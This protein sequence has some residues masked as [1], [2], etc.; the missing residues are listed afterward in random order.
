MNGTAN[1]YMAGALGI[2]STSLT[3]FTLRLDKNITGSANP[4][5]FSAGG[6]IQTDATGVVVLIGT[7]LQTVA[8]ANSANV[9]HYNTGTG[10]IGAG[11]V[12]GNLYGYVASG[13]TQGTNNFGFYGNIAAAANRYNLY[14][15]GTANNYMAGSLGIGTTSF[16]FGGGTYNLNLTKNITGTVV[17]GGMNIGSIVNS[18]VTSAA[19][20]LNVQVTTAA[21]AF[22]LNQLRHISVNQTTL[23]AGS[24]VSNQYG[25]Y[26]DQI[27]NGS[28]NFGFFGNVPAG[29][30]RWNIY[31]AGTAN[32]FLAGSLGI[33]STALTQYNVRMQK[34][35]TGAATSFGMWI[36]SPI[37]SDVTT[38]A[39]IFG[40]SPST[41]AA[42]FTLG[43]LY[44]FY[45]NQST[46]GAGSSITNQ[47]GFFADSGL[48]GATND[49]GFFGNLA[50]GT[51]I[52][53]LYMA[54]TAANYMAGNLSIGTTSTTYQLNV[55]GGG[56]AGVLDSAIFAATG[57]GG[58]GRGVGIVL[59]ASGSSSS[60]QVARLVGYQ[61][62]ASATANNAS[63]AIQV[64]NSSG[65]LTERVRVKTG[66]QMRFVPLAADPSGA[67]AGDVYYNSTTNKLKVYNGTAWETITSL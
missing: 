23:G 21:A 38:G 52:W 55:Q 5:A 65:T 45:A 32:N 12:I 31:M 51:N 41:Q 36:D 34:N 61:E 35:I 53:N 58:A 14:M 6:T 16:V 59:G 19:I 47:Y 26:V 15:N 9:Y 62:T 3:G 43:N 22:T 60:V 63:F 24:S 54:G 40:T 18:D 66:G 7:S 17:A 25:V 4:Q 11:T 56:V 46:I 37:S 27:T 30:N 42:A 1:N 8:S 28:S 49:Y 13:L 10:S 67:E 48:T 39:A 50:S 44:H 20:G 57:N 29:T 33:G 2:G 64:A